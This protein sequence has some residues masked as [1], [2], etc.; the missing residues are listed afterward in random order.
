MGNLLREVVTIPRRKVCCSVDWG[1]GREFD[2]SSRIRGWIF[3]FG[4]PV[5]CQF[6]VGGMLQTLV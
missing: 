6:T 3:L 1:L 4:Y 2:E 5:F